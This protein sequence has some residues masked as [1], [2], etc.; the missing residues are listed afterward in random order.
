MNE[1]RAMAAKDLSFRIKQLRDAKKWSQGQL[2]QK[3][4]IE[5]QRISKYERGVIFPT[6]DVMIKLSEALGVSLDF[7]IKGEGE[8][9]INKIPNRELVKRFD[10]ISR[11][12]DEEQY[13]LILV[14]D[15]FIKKQRFEAVANS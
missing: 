8:A 11:L 2:A 13:A 10:Q 12:T 15:A 14:M 6:V 3:M 7:L 9:D 5:Y 4:G 1:K